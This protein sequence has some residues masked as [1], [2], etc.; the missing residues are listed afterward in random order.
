MQARAHAHGER[1]RIAAQRNTAQ[2]SA[3]QRL[4][5]HTHMMHC[6]AIQH[7]ATY[8]CFL[9]CI[10]CY[11]PPGEHCC[12]QGLRASRDV[13]GHPLHRSLPAALGLCRCCATNLDAATGETGN[14]ASWS[15]VCSTNY[16]SSSSEYQVVIRADT[17]T[18]QERRPCHA[19]AYLIWGSVDPGQVGTDFFTCLIWPRSAGH[20]PNLWQGSHALIYL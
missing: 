8:G 5:M 15:T 20:A 10:P 2:C 6:I 3:A 14:A 18:A 1:A 11:A 19:P 17:R 7:N 12:K 9:D 13:C 16:I 4:Q